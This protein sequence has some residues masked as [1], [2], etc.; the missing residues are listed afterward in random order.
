MLKKNLPIYYINRVI[1]KTALV[2]R[3]EFANKL[4]CSE[5]LSYE[6]ITEYSKLS[7]ERVKEIKA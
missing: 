5:D 7:L 4:L 3:I 1:P 6:R 2:E